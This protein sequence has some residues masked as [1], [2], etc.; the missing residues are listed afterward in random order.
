MEGRQE[1][2]ALG[3]YLGIKAGK[4]NEGDAVT[5]VNQCL[6][7]WEVPSLSCV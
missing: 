3:R 1:L 4:S 6:A 2:P 7:G 5:R